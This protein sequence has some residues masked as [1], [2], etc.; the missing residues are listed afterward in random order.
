MRKM[1]LALP[2]AVSALVSGV[3]AANAQSVVITDDDGG[4]HWDHRSD[5]WH[6]R[7]WHHHDRDRGDWDRR[8]WHHGDWHHHCMVKTTEIHRHG[9]M[10]I[11]RDR[12]CR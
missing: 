1:L 4:P 7:D 11:K 2:L 5:E 9:H 6:H 3:N 10:I 12:I 8:D